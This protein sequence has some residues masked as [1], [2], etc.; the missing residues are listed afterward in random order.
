MLM[1]KEA[2]TDVKKDQ[3]LIFWADNLVFA[4]PI[5]WQQ[6]SAMLKAFID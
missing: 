4:Y 5:W 1:G 3:K 2:P 6:M